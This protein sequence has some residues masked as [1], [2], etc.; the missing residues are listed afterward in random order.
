MVQRR[1][2]STPESLRMSEC[3][4]LLSLWPKTQGVCQNSWTDKDNWTKTFSSEEI[5]LWGPWPWICLTLRSCQR[6]SQAGSEGKCNTGKAW[7]QMLSPWTDFSL[8]PH[9]RTSPCCYLMVPQCSQKVYL[10]YRIVV[11][12][13]IFWLIPLLLLLFFLLYSL[14]A[15]PTSCL[16]VSLN[17]WSKLQRGVNQ[18]KALPHSLSKSS[19]C[20]PDPVMY[21]LGK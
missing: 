17:I 11:S 4:W 7:H 16:A 15:D 18:L 12:I 2:K 10:H 9:R 19:T 6:I 20:G 8:W 1:S 3:L 5:T 14:T 13:V 21:Y